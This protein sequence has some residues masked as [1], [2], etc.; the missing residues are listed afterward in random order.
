MTAPE[1]GLSS[2]DKLE[3][4]LA[5]ELLWELGEAAPAKAPGTPGAPR[6]YSEW[7]WYLYDA[8]VS[9][10]LSARK[11]AAE[12]SSAWPV[13]IAAS[14]AQYPDH[15]EMWAPAEPP[16][17][18]HW[19]YAKKRLRLEPILRESITTFEATSV[20]Q[21][22]EMGIANP[23]LGSVS[24]PDA[25]NALTGDG[26]VIT[27]LYRAKRRTPIVDKETAEILG[28]KK[29]DPTA[30][31]HVEGG[32][33]PAYGNKVVMIAGRTPDWHGRMILSFDKVATKSGE[34][35][36]AIDCVERIRWRLP[37]VQTLI[38]D[39]AIR[40]VHVRRLLHDLGLIPISPPTAAKAETKETAREE[41]VAFIE[42]RTNA[43]GEQIS[44]YAF[45]SQ[46]GVG[47][48]DA[49]GEETFHPLTRLAIKKRPNGDGT[50]RWYGA[51]RL[52]DHFGGETILVRADTTDD[53]VNRGVNR[54][55]NYRLIPP[56]DPD[57]DALYPLR[58]DIEANNRQLE[59]TLWIG[60]AHS[61]GADAQLLDLLGYALVYNSVAIGL[62]RHRASS[63]AA[64]AA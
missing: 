12:L 25:L 56:G 64:A 41:K 24:H 18:H 53:D 6:Q 13:V 20:M 29:A 39:G 59:D 57:Y 62:A 15:P 26:K 21:A 51:Y 8:A 45:G 40:G 4:V 58:S 35:Q 14:K 61:V 44:L 2:G 17:R 1:E 27:P 60:R 7:V 23:D 9:I 52:P 46:L 33:H 55:E 22:R 32:G 63:Q 54:S 16:S 43:L 31:L 30:L 5:N 19:Q 48:F 11:G 28:Y 49:D 37:G 50:F 38:Y 10:Y 42:A 34:A 36:V 3:F 47:E